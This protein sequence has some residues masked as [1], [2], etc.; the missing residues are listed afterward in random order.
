MSCVG[1]GGFHSGEMVILFSPSGKYGVKSLCAAT[2]AKRSL[3]SPLCLPREIARTRF[4]EWMT[5][6]GEDGVL[7]G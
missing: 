5:K 3:A 1:T 2:P 7:Q 6:G 4:S